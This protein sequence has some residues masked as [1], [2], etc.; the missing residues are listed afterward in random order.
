MAFGCAK[1]SKTSWWPTIGLN[2]SFRDQ[3]LWAQPS[4]LKRKCVWACLHVCAMWAPISALLLRPFSL[5]AI[6]SWVYFSASLV[7][8]SLHI[9][10]KSSIHSLPTLSRGF[11]I[12]PGDCTAPKLFLTSCL[13]WSL[14]IVVDC[15]DAAPDALPGSSGWTGSP[16]LT[17]LNLMLG[18]WQCDPVLPTI[19]FTVVET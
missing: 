10:R 14:L 19:S 16:Q 7:L 3:S 17:H 6:Y 13:V 11:L 9:P 8:L 2:F 1:P 5:P 12:C 18:T 15:R 4:P